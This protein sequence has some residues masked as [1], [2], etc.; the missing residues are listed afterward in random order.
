MKK[1]IVLF[2][3]FVMVISILVSCG[4]DSEKNDDSDKNDDV[5]FEENIDLDGAEVIFRTLLAVTS[6]VFYPDIAENARGDKIRD[7]YKDTDEKFNCVMNIQT[8]KEA[9]G[10]KVFITPILAGIHYADFFESNPKFIFSIYKAGGIVPI[11]DVWDE[12]TIHNGKWGPDNVLKTITLR[13]DLLGVNSGYWGIPIPNMENVLY[14]NNKLLF[15]L[16][17]PHPHEL[18][19]QGNWDWAHYRQIG[20][21]V[22]NSQDDEGKNYNFVGL[23]NNMVSSAVLSNG[24]KYA[25]DNGDGTYT[26]SLNDEKTYKALSWLREM[27]EMKLIKTAVNEKNFTD[28]K[29]TAFYVMPVWWGYRY[30]EKENWPINAFSEGGYSWSQFPKGPDGSD[31]DAKSGGAFINDRFVS[32]TSSG[33][34]E[35]ENIGKIMDFIFDPLDGEEKDTWKKDFKRDHFYDSS[36]YITTKTDHSYEVYTNMLENANLDM[37]MFMESKRDAIYTAL[38][39]AVTGSKTPAET[40]EALVSGCQ[41]E[42]D[43]FSNYE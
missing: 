33:F 28:K 42:L 19:E 21:A 14:V 43:N 22:V 26:F 11:S 18:N 27:F 35:P 37:I 4:T 2:L 20:E 13:G 17:Q 39:S 1:I 38:K 40:I 12:K 29:D 8:Y 5:V 15:D 16:Q 30:N 25:K 3:I 6:S 34:I 10:S 32:I 9:D 24:A 23:N 31:N 36:D 7:R 41:A